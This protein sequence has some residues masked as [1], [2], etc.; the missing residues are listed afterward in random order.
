MK[1]PVKRSI[2]AFVGRSVLIDSSFSLA[3]T[4]GV[5]DKTDRFIH[6]GQDM[7]ARSL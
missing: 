1:T 5:A 7:P 6:N 2:Q 3:G 4:A